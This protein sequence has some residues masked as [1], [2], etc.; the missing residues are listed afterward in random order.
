M[1]MAVSK[2][3][4]AASAF[5]GLRNFVKVLQPRRKKVI[6]Q[7]LSKVWET[8][9]RTKWARNNKEHKYEEKTGHLQPE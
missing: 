6:V 9:E 4:A 2:G 8:K 1:V 7:G 3:Y 5:S